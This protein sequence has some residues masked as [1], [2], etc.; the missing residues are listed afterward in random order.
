MQKGGCAMNEKMP[1]YTSDDPKEVIKYVYDALKAKGHDP[2]LQ[3][4]GYIVS[5]D[6][7]Y[8]TAYGGAR[9]LIGRVERDELLEEFVKEYFKRIDKK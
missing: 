1:S 8:I 6:P 5:G 7:T 2:V 4:V 9:T 3:M